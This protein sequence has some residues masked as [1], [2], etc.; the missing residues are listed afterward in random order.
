MPISDDHALRD[1]DEVLFRQTHP[2]WMDEG[3]PVS[4]HFRPNS[5]DSGQLSSDRGSLVTPREAFEAYLAKNRKTAGTWGLTVG[6]CGAEGLKSYSD[7]LDDNHAHALIDFSGHDDK[8]QRNI[9][10]K[11]FRLAANRGCLYPTDAAT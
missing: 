10:K 7:P 6:E 4:R 9:S 8:A 1:V 11:L 3:R 5:F 2:D